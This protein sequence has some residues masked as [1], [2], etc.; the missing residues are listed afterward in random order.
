MF[1]VLAEQRQKVE[2]KR[3]WKV[4]LARRHNAS[5]AIRTPTW[6][7]P[8]I[9]NAHALEGDFWENLVG[10]NLQMV[11]ARIIYAFYRTWATFP[12]DRFN[13]YSKGC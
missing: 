11:R 7:R 5:G 9:S 12:T 4:G 1:A 10:W 8:A 3:L 2:G 6:W 13:L